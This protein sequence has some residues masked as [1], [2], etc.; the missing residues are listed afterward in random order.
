MNKVVI[1]T[2]RLNIVSRSIAELSSL[3]EQETDQEMKQAYSEM[4]ETMRKLPGKE[5][6][7]CDWSINLTSGV[8]IGGIC[9]K[10]TPDAEGVVE[11]GYG[12]EEEYRQKGYAT[13]AVKGFVKW[14]LEHNEVK[15]VVAQTDIH[16][17]ISQKVLIRNGFLQ[18]G[19][20]EEGPLFNIIK[21]SEKEE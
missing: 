10:G 16:N 19:Y 13:E 14:A 2:E 8:T 1:K 15:C 11:I 21:T 12:I 6:W 17:E 9:F 20:G 5:E 3:L 4:I 7:G 18:D